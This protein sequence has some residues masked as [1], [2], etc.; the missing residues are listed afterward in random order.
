MGHRVLVIFGDKFIRTYWIYK[1]VGT[2]QIIDY[3]C[4]LFT[5]DVQRL[6]MQKPKAWFIN[7]IKNRQTRSLKDFVIQTVYLSKE[8]TE[9]IL[10]LNSNEMMFHGTLKYNFLHLDYGYW[11]T[12]DHLK[13]SEIT[14]FSISTSELTEH[15]MNQ[16]LK[17]LMAG[18]CPQ[19]KFLSVGINDIDIQNIFV[20]IQNKVV[21]VTEKRTITAPSQRSYTFY[22]S[23][24]IRNE[25]GTKYSIC[26]HRR[27]TLVIAVQPG[28]FQIG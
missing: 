7:F 24:D 22:K 26:L 18:G 5:M 9:L 27:N 23:F 4:D 8:E 13:N 1:E 11:V 3:I 25:G 15:D 20:D 21:E 6:S 12:L 2:Q 10:K 19:L 14:E 16:F 28:D 17:H